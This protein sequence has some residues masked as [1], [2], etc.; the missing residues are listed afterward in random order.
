MCTF[1]LIWPH[2]VCYPSSFVISLFKRRACEFLFWKSGCSIVIKMNLR[3]LLLS[4]LLVLFNINIIFVITIVVIGW[5]CLLSPDI[6]FPH[7]MSITVDWTGFVTTWNTSLYSFDLWWSFCVINRTETR[8]G[9]PTGCCEGEA[10]HS[11]KTIGLAL[12]F[13]FAVAERAAYCSSLLLL[14]L[15]DFSRILS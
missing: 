9:L 6:I 12:T 8:G 7:H 10:N 1:W 14:Q 11:L 2:S 4:L 15:F 3:W 13:P 5:H